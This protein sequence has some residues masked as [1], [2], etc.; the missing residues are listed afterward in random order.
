MRS[1]RLVV[2]LLI[3]LMAALLAAGA[4]L[5]ETVLLKPQVSEPQA[6]QSELTELSDLGA[7]TILLMGGFRG[8]AVNVLWLKSIDLHER[9]RYHDER[10]ILDIISKLQPRY[11][12]VWVFQAWNI[13][14][15]ISVQ[16]ETDEEQFKWVQEGKDFLLKGQKILPE[17]A[18]IAFW[19]GI[20]Y[21]HK[22]GYRPAYGELLEKCEGKNNY[23]E[24]AIWFDRARKL[25]RQ[26]RA[27]S[28]FHPR[29]ADTGVFHCYE[30]RYKQIL[31]RGSLTSTGF[32]SETLKDAE[33]WRKRALTEAEGLVERWPRDP[34]FPYFKVRIGA[35]GLDAYLFHVRKTMLAGGLSEA[36]DA[37]SRPLLKLAAGELKRLRLK[38][39]GTDSGPIL[40]RRETNILICLPMMYF[41]AAT[42]V[43]TSRADPPPESVRN[44]IG[45]LRRARRMMQ[46]AK[47]KMK[48]ENKELDE[49]FEYVNK[50][51]KQCNG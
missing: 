7:A 22:Y 33:P 36:A 47:L 14:Y 6:S 18:D 23:E 51:L 12:S 31:E 29:L 20:M 8:L 28:V 1:S 32:D 38:Y 10:A 30:S 16:Y 13:A 9:R 34:V 43:L 35:V 15:N 11:A 24:G 3:L 26:G 50:L 4:F 27:L 39:P 41:H 17:N 49:L 25:I 19:L 42:D 5:K 46:N 45:W 21:S 2:T 48:T 40:T 37:K 44:A